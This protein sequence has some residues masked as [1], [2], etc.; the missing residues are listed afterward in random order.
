[1]HASNAPVS[2]P[3]V[4]DQ[5]LQSGQLVWRQAAAQFQLD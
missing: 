2:P 5:Q 4:V 3:Q 1:M